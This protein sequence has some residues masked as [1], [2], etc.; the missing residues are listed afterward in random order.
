MMIYIK[1]IK[2]I[3]YFYRRIFVCTLHSN[4]GVILN[5]IMK[6]RLGG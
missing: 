2:L 1:Y 3:I 5:I 4:C 6:I